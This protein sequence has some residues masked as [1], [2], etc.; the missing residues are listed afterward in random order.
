MFV[1]TDPGLF[2]EMLQIRVGLIMEVLA[3]EYAR[4]S[5]FSGKWNGICLNI[6]IT[7]FY[8]STV[9]STSN[10]ITMVILNLSGYL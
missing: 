7:I 4:V 3:A 10:K 8:L 6:V 2:K 9:E 5:G 1:K